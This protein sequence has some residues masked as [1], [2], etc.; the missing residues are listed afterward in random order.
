M[1]AGA[2]TVLSLR[3]SGSR[4]SNRPALAGHT[5]LPPHTHNSL[6]SGCPVQA[7]TMGGED[8]SALGLDDR[9]EKSM[10]RL[11]Q[12]F[13]QMFML[14][15]TRSL[16]LDEAARALLGAQSMSWEACRVAA[17]CWFMLQLVAADGCT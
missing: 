13:V 17:P 5:Q 11:S 9:K 3:G 12:R 8:L 6:R 10:S 1:K 4:C 14:S 2:H 16:G 15:K 7:K